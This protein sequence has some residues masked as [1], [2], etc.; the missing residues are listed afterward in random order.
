MIILDEFSD[1]A[2]SSK[3]RFASSQDVEAYVD[4][5]VPYTDQLEEAMRS[6]PLLDQQPSSSPRPGPS[7][8]TPAPL[9]PSYEATVYTQ[10]YKN[11]YKQGRRRRWVLPL[12][13]AVLYLLVAAAILIPWILSKVCRYRTRLF[14]P[15]CSPH[16]RGASQSRSSTGKCLQRCFLLSP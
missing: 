10:S 8:E 3:A 15:R 2:A 12:A 7:T 5:Y 6:N 13:L 4:E 14:I 11:W 9:P 1:P 16:F